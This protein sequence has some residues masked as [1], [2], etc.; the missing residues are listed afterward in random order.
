MKFTSIKYGED[1]CESIT[2]PACT[3]LAVRR[4]REAAACLCKH[5]KSSATVLSMRNDW[6]L[7]T[8]VCTETFQ[9]TVD[10]K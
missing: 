1:T 10:K 6:F 8:K 4:N 3:F 9:R 5:G 2:G 7:R